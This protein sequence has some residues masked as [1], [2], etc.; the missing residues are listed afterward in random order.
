MTEKLLM[1]RYFS[2]ILQIKFLLSTIFSQ[3]LAIFRWKFNF[4]RNFNLNSEFFKPYFC[5]TK[6]LSVWTLSQKNRDLWLTWGGNFKLKLTDFRIQVLK[7]YLN[8]I[9]HLKFSF[10]PIVK[11]QTLILMKIRYSRMK[12]CF[13]GKCLFETITISLYFTLLG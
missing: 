9:Q 7:N 12:K 2:N 1:F 13:S 10:W 3:N 11:D 4:Q 5:C 8:K 6:F